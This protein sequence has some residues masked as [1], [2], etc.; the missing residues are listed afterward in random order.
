MVKAEFGIE[1]KVNL[2]QKKKIALQW[3]FRFL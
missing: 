2:L 3:R 1:K